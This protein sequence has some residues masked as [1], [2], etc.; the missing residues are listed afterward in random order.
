MEHSLVQQ[1]RG[2]RGEV[3]CLLKEKV[4][5][6]QTCSIAEQVQEQESCGGRLS[7]APRRIQVSVNEN[8]SLQLDS[9]VIL[10]IPP[11]TTLAYSIIELDVKLN[12]EYG[13]QAVVRRSLPS[14]AV[15]GGEGR[16]PAQGRV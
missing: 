1:S 4:F 9:N 10:E 2:R 16:S 8:G 7:F 11:K 15:Q 13:E 12:G 5:T 14:G 6:T 3:F